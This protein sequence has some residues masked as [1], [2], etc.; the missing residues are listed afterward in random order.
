[1]LSKTVESHLRL[2][3]MLSVG[4]WLLSALLL[5]LASYLPLFDSSPRV[6]LDGNDSLFL[7]WDAF[8]FGHIAKEFYVYEHEWAFFPGLPLFIMRL[9][10]F[11]L[12]WLGILQSS[13]PFTWGN[14]LKS[15]ALLVTTTGANTTLYELT[16]RLTGSPQMALLSSLL[17]LL[18]SSPATL[19]LVPYTEPFFTFLSYK[20]MFRIHLDQH[21]LNVM[22]VGMLYCANSNWFRALACFWF[23]SYFRS[24]GFLLSGFIVWGMLVEPVLLRQKAS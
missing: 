5:Y 12:H 10:A 19:R 17:S 23:A 7:R 15:G 18:P 3:R 6:V 21:E 14:V 8:H 24:N 22:S 4:T 16:L 9:G 20:G 13:S 1:M 11:V 2:L